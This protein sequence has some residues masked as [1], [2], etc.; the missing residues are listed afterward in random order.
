MSLG[1]YSLS[2]NE[3]KRLVDCISWAVYEHKILSEL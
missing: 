3:P 1:D 2:F